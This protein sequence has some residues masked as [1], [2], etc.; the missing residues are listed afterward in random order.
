[1]GHTAKLLSTELR[2]FANQL[3]Y[4]KHGYSAFD[5]ETL[6]LYTDKSPEGILGS[7]S[8]QNKFDQRAVHT[9]FNLSNEIDFLRKH[10][11][12]S[13]EKM[14]RGVLDVKARSDFPTRP[15]TKKKF[16]TEQ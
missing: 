6:R 15:Q 8:L 16:Q 13:L 10:N 11:A 1:M 12:D 7:K 2:A 14:L 9:K 5:T 3:R 4:H